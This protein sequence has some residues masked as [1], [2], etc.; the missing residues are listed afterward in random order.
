M[1]V[2]DASFLLILTYKIY[3]IVLIMLLW[4]AIVGLMYTL[5]WWY[6]YCCRLLTYNFNCIGLPM[7]KWK[8]KKIEFGQDKNET[9]THI[10][11]MDIFS[12]CYS[13]L[14]NDY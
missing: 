3:T 10:V 12:L 4:N 9:L 6:L 8:E 13:S 5:S 2:L 11:H 14:N 1:S 7:R